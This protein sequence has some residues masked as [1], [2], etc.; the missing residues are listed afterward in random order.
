[1]I[2]RRFLGKHTG[3]S[4]ALDVHTRRICEQW[5]PLGPERQGRGEECYS[6][7][8]RDAKY[9]GANFPAVVN[10]QLF[11]NGVAVR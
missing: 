3:V 6:N 11:C 7:G 10:N 2:C 5:E 4:A 1:V 9:V 8:Y